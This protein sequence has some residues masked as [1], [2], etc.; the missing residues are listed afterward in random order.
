LGW[1]L[2]ELV[3]GDFAPGERAELFRLEDAALRIGPSIC[4]EDTAAV[5]TREPVLLGA[6]LLVNVTNDGWFGLSA[7]AEQHLVNAIFRT[8]ENRRP[9][10]RC[11]NTG[12]TCFIDAT[13]RVHRHGQNPAGADTDQWP[14][15]FEEGVA[16]VKL[17]IPT[18]QGITFY[19][20]HGDVFA[21]SCAMLAGVCAVGGALWRRRKRKAVV[22]KV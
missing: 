17:R 8:V 14:K 1:A 16:K 12:M 3:P 11:T 9:L 18:G 19:S 15:A 6:D 7:G 5:L 4:F 21:A 22:A 13:G 10:L 20:R 2:A